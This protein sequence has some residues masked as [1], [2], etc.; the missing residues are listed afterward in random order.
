MRAADATLTTDAHGRQ[1][2]RLRVARLLVAAFAVCLASSVGA[3]AE[4]KRIFVVSSY[5]KE[6]LWSQSNQEGLSAA[7]RK[8]GYLDNE[9]Q[10]EAFA[11]N[12]YVES[13]KAIVKRDWMNT[14]RRNDRSNIVEATRR[15]LQA[16]QE[17]APDLVMLGDDNAANYIGNQLLDTDV[18]VV[19][20]GIN[21]LPLK[22]GLVESMD[23]P[24]HNVTG[25]WQAGYHKES[26]ELLKALVPN[27]ETF[28]ILTCD[29]TTSRAVTKQIQALARRK[30]LP[31]RLVDTVM[32]NSFS[33][34]KRETLAL[35]TRVDAFFVL[36]HDTFRDDNG[37]HVP[38]L[39]VVRWYLENIRIPEAAMGGTSVREGLL[40]AA[41]DSGYNQAYLAFEKAYDILEHG[42]NPGRIRTS[43][44]PR[45]PLM[46]NR[47]RA[48]MLGISIRDKMDII[49]EIVEGAVAL[50][51]S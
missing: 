40:L 28:A 24:G 15:I 47:K 44:P 35:A 4:K 17:F 38:L 7:M 11:R 30:E 20:W 9:R 23:S 50:G 27:A 12:D 37:K 8:Y 42:L 39:E 32:T 43:T 19:F 22:Y 5:H 13:S 1:S 18:P 21:G 16:I 48:Q 36:N 6:Y 34:F 31:L 26:L 45:G 25:V 51:G 10:I 46:V 41:K 49:E 29:S 2:V 33:E 3:A 14:K